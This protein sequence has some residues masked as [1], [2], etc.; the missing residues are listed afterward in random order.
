MASVIKD[1]GIIEMIDARLLVHDQEEITAG[2]AVAGMIL[3]GLGFSNRPLSLTPQFFVNTPLDLL[4]HEG[5]KAE[6]FNRFKLGR[7]LSE[8]HAYG[9][10]VLFSEVAMA[11][12]AQEG[13]DQRFTHLDTT[14][15]SLTGDY[16]PESDEHAIAIT[17]GYSKDHRPD[18]KQAVL[19]LMVSQDGGVPLMSKSWDGNA[20]DTIV[21][22]ERARALLATFQ[23]SPSPRY[24]V[25][26][27]K[28]YHA[29]NAENL[30][31]LRFITRIPHTLKVVLH[32][33]T[34]ALEMD[35]WH[36][37][38]AQLRYQ[39]FELCH[40][41]IEQRW[42]VVFSQAAALRAHAAVSKA[43]HKEYDAIQQQLFHLQAQRFTSQTLAQEALG[44]FGKKW[45]YHQVES[46]EL[47]AHKRYGKKGRPTPDTQVR[48]TEWQIAAHVR[49]DAERIK[50]AKQLGSC[51]VL[52]SNI[53]IDQLSDV[54]IIAGYKGQAQAEGGFR[55]LKDP[56]FFV[57]SLFVK[58]PSRIQGLLMV[59][60]LSLLVY[61]VAQRRLR[62]ALARQN[63]TLPNQINQ[64]TSRPTLRWVFQLLE[65]IHRV[66]VTV[67]EQVHTLIEGLNEVRIKI[68][69][70]F[71]ERVCQVYQ[72]SSG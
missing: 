2:E 67:Q 71:G 51:F 10:D 29:D 72:I 49:P 56:L 55:F 65:G 66:Q 35:T 28:L 69:R 27:S 26:D 9:C 50:Y 46:S 64:P 70:L 16:L 61:S 38:D 41:G 17:H 20:S 59:M 34:Q 1:L 54:E 40:Y 53:A 25:A 22:Q 3:N 43:Q 11:V 48:A 4:F 5:V 39:R 62:Q 14:S 7:T 37:A 21:F 68:L 58:K 32:V 23:R 30:K 42:L 24:V 13:V 63:D 6:M 45:R 18:L 33:L 60:T 36:D 15:F 52:G 8:V 44:T 12:C 31:L 57:S 19:E 47:T